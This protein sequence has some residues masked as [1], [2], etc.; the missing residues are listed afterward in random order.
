MK[1][2]LFALLCISGAWS[3][4]A[5]NTP[6]DLAG[7]DKI[8]IKVNFSRL[9][10]KAGTASQA[11][12]DQKL[13]IDG[14]QMPE[15]AKI[16]VSKKGSTLLIQE[17]KPT[18][19]GISDRFE[20][21]YWMAVNGDTSSYYSGSVIRQEDDLGPQL[22]AQ[23]TVI[24]PADMP[25]EVENE[26]GAIRIENINGLQQAH[27]VYGTVEVVMAN[28]SNKPLAV[29]SE[30]GA[31]D[32]SL[33]Q[34]VNADLALKTDYGI[35]YTDFDIDINTNDSR[36]TAFGETVIG[37]IGRGGANI[38]CKAPYGNVYLRRYK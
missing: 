8:K 30:Y 25:L 37:T 9:V 35:L 29:S 3:L 14:E 1:N 15:M 10:V 34:S 24:I 21:G 16:S 18:V 20:K 27:T 6:L 11:A 4:F 31:V 36:K 38:S 2:L 13:A 26:Y 22:E 32:L 33:G 19:D 5:Q 12:V 7:V 17:V 28:P 23:I